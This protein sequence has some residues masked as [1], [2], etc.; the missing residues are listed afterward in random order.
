MHK[1]ILTVQPKRTSCL[2]FQVYLDSV[3]C[4]VSTSKR[5]HAIFSHENV[6]ILQCDPIYARWFA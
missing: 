1:S 3:T 4:K 6:I 5:D 2:C